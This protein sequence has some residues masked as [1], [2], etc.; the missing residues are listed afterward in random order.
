[1]RDGEA[2][3]FHAVQAADLRER[4]VRFHSVGGPVADRVRQVRSILEASS[5]TPYSLP[6]ACI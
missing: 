6:A 1:M 2:E 3:R 4:G 5:A